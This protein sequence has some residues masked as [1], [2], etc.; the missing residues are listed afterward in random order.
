MI[1][2]AV[3][4]SNSPSQSSV[5]IT[6]EGEECEIIATKE[7]WSLQSFRQLVPKAGKYKLSATANASSE[8]V[9]ICLSKVS[10][11]DR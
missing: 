2:Y 1:F 11:S 3:I 5:T 7:A 9:E 10:G 4:Y 6:I 8:K